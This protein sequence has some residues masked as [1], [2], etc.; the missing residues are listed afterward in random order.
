MNNWL[1][2]LLEVSVCQVLFGLLYCTVFRNLSFFQ[3]NRVF[4]LTVTILSF[5]I[6][7]L[8]IPFWNAPVS[9]AS[10]SIF[11]RLQHVELAFDPGKTMPTH[12]NVLDVN[13]LITIL[14]L[15]YLTGFTLRFWKLFSGIISVLK[16]TRINKFFEEDGVKIIYI[17]SGPSFFSFLNYIFINKSHLA[18]SEEEFSQVIEHEKTHIAQRHTLDNLLMEVSI[19][20][21]WFNPV[22]RLMKKE[23]NT[24]HEYYADAKASAFKGNNESYSKLLL[25]LASNKG[26][27]LLTHQF[28]MNTF[29]KRIIM[30]NETK[31]KKR[32]ALRY[33]LVA[34][35]IM[36]LLV[37]FSFVPKNSNSQDNL[38]IIDTPY[39][40]G[41]ISWKGNSLYS[42]DYLSGYLG[43]KKG[44]Q[45][46]EEMINE[47]LSYQPEGRDL[48]SLFMD[49]G[50][51]YFTLEM[52]KEIKDHKV[53][54]TFD[55]FEGEVSIIDKV[56][57]T[58]NNKVST[59]QILKMVDTVKGELFSRSKLMSSQKKIIE[60]GL[61]DSE[62]LTPNIIP[63]PSEGTVDI[64][65]NVVEL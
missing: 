34:P 35:C 41:N 52:N 25:K 43:L 1:V 24:V 26:S 15:V 12:V 36:L 65:F 31:N 6:P 27:S 61:F 53:D 54:I 48:G 59:A 45:F 62:K 57:I 51:L 56:L 8:S 14:G 28:S 64:E 30:L 55:I 32:I 44:D 47:K 2:Y 60:S 17:N 10:L 33:I 38:A 4:L 18:I 58:G 13:W 5:I 46:N 19:L 29:K 3:T 63:H 21:C 49:Y 42:D 7:L 11:Q 22:L 20:I 16:L 50:Y 9:D 39:I 40:I 23:L 37:A